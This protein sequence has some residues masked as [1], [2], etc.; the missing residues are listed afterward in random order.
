MCAGASTLCVAIAAGGMA[1]SAVAQAQV[2]PQA[3]PKAVESLSEVVVVA[4]K[5]SERLVDVPISVA[6]MNGDQLRRT[7]THNVH[8]VSELVPNFTV[9]EDQSPGVS[10][11]YI[12]GIGTSRNGQ[13]PVAVSVD[14]VQISNSYE[15]TQD[16]LDVD[17]IEVLK[18][19]QGALYGRNAIGGAIVIQT[20]QPA[21]EFEGSVTAGWAS[22]DSGGG[23]VSD[24]RY[25]ATLS[26]PI[27]KDTLLFKLAYSGRDFDGDII[28]RGT[29]RGDNPDNEQNFRGGLLFKPTSNLTFDLRVA[30]LN[31]RAGGA[32]YQQPSLDAYGGP[33]DTAAEANRAG[34]PDAR[35]NNTSYRY[36]TDVSLKTTIALPKFDLTS[37]TAWSD[38]R[39]DLKQDASAFTPVD[40]DQPIRTQA[41]SEEI[42]LTSNTPGPLK[43][44]VGGYYIQTSYAQNLYVWLVNPTGP[45]G[46]GFYL[47]DTVTRETLSSYAGFGQVSYRFANNIELTGSFRYDVDDQRSKLL[48]PGGVSQS[49][50]SFQ[51][52][53]SAAYYLSP[54]SQVYAY[55]ARGYRSGGFN[56]TTTYGASYRPEGVWTYE[57]GYK[58][59]S[60]DRKYSTDLA[61]F[62]NDISD[63]Q[64]FFLKPGPTQV[65]GTPI[66][67]AESYGA[68][69]DFRARPI[70]HLLLEGAIG[71][72]DS[73]SQSYD[74]SIP[75]VTSADVVGKQL[76]YSPHVS[77]AVSARYEFDIGG[78]KVTPQ[79]ETTGYG[80]S[81][82]EIDNV[83]PRKSENITNVRLSIDYHNTD[84]TLYSENIFHVLRNEEFDS[85]RF[86]GVAVAAMAPGWRSGLTLTQHF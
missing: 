58:W 21:N 27:I 9:T 55:A 46:S 45:F 77:Y 13:P 20:R 80:A 82:W 7:D 24:W 65:I 70:D 52:K 1:S 4:R 8:D 38:V 35:V 59:L 25:G 34:F 30:S 84:V 23:G 22:A 10:L 72:L 49:F 26:G 64:I 6:V 86:A 15:I 37:V 51:P 36:I 32:W 53:F 40:A 19:P 42:R 33:F 16:L 71:L 3:A 11:I 31:Q 63:M 78:F 29:G 83:Y 14:G 47:G 81:Y 18:G 69:A 74:N 50:D 76:P 62:Y 43:W 41:G 85:A 39:T 60:Q 54:Q 12:R 28:N 67:R 44:M 79:I 61:L 56:S 73:R 17:Q 48:E 2:T 57:T 75:G 68:E 5:R 66:T